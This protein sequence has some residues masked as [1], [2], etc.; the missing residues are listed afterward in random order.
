MEEEI[1][2]NQNLYQCR[3]CG[4][5]YKD[6]A[7]AEKCEAWCKEH[8]TC[9]IEII[10]EAEENKSFDSAQDKLQKLEKKCEEYLNNWKRAE[11]DFANYKK[12]EMERMAFW[13]KYAKEDTIL[14][15]L[16]ILDSFY[17]AEKQ[18]PEKLKSGQEGN[19]PAI[20][21]TK[22]F[23]QIKNQISE[24]LKKEGIE[25]IETAGKKFDPE[26]MEILEEVSGGPT[27]AESGMVVEE[28]QKG[29]IMDDKVLRPAKVKVSK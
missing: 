1:K 18:L 17:L 6:K 10:R 23:L 14:K 28:L 22:G 5:H 9:N 3:E 12:D 20:E 25:A 19:A 13:G 11:A 26:T 7:A 8:K 15:I 4:F 2:N 29:Y 21:W 24:F 16:P 27:P